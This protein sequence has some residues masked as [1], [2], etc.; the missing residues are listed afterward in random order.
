MRLLAI[1]DPPHL[2][3]PQ[4]D[5]SVA[6]LDEVLRRGHEVFI[7]E[8]GELWL[9]GSPGADVRQVQATSRTT[10][11][12]L[13]VTDERI[14]KPLSWFNAVFMRKDPPFDPTYLWATQILEHA[15]GQTLLV[16]DPRGL[17]EANEKLYIFHFQDLIPP[18]IVTRRLDELRAFLEE[19]GGK[20]VVKPL[21]GFGGAAVFLVQ[22]GDPNINAIL[23]VS[24]LNGHRWV[25]AQRYLPEGKKGDKRILLLD[26]EPLGCFLRVPAGDDIRSNMAVGG[27]PTASTLSE[28][29]RQI[30][31]RVRP[32]LL[33][34][35]LYFVGLDVIGDYLSE[36]NVTSPTGVQ[37]IDR[38]DG[39]RI[40]ANIA[41]WLEKNAV[42][43][44]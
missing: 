36:V 3:K 14:A 19:Q 41:D 8:I 6:I 9:R 35:G 26:G 32:R 39:V 1:V 37:A 16:N 25:M 10:R 11:P 20:I 38:L 2:L 4:A 17:R 18:T 27:T 21:D 7:C 23:E 28:R 5:T 42:H 30:I 12:A 31:E 34:D 24:T 40:E 44:A 13:T 43:S 15:R 33:K 29:D 22:K